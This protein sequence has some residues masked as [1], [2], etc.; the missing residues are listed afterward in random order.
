MLW[1]A[2]QLLAPPAFLAA[3]PGLASALSSFQPPASGVWWWPLALGVVAWMAWQGRGFVARSLRWVRT[4]ILLVA[5]S[6]P[7]VR[8]V[9]APAQAPRPPVAEAMKILQRANTRRYIPSHPMVAD[10]VRKL[11]VDVVLFED[12]KEWEAFHRALGAVKPFTAFPDGR[13]VLGLSAT[14]G[15]LALLHEVV[16]I[17]ASDWVGRRIDRRPFGGPDPRVQLYLNV[18]WA[19]RLDLPRA[20][21][22]QA[23]QLFAA[24]EQQFKDY[25]DPDPNEAVWNRE[26]QQQR[27]FEERWRALGF[28]LPSGGAAREYPTSIHLELPAFIYETWA[29]RRLGFPRMYGQALEA[30]VEAYFGGRLE[31]MR[32]LRGDMDRLVELLRRSPRATAIL[33]KFYREIKLPLPATTPPSPA[34]PPPAPGDAAAAASDQRFVAAGLPPR[35]AGRLGLAL[36]EA[37]HVTQ[38]AAPAQAPRAPTATQQVSRPPKPQSMNAV[39]AS[40]VVATFLRWQEAVWDQQQVELEWS[41]A[42]QR[43]WSWF[44]PPRYYDLGQVRASASLQ[45]WAARYPRL[46]AQFDKLSPLHREVTERAGRLRKGLEAQVRRAPSLMPQVIRGLHESSA[47]LISTEHVERL[48]TLDIKRTEAPMSDEA[49]RKAHGNEKY[50][51]ETTSIAILRELIR[52]LPLTREDV[53]VDIGTGYAVP[54]FYVA[55]TTPARARG[56]EL[57]THRIQE[58]MRVQRRFRF[59]RVELIEG[60]VLSQDLSDGTVFFL[61]NPLGP[62]T[63]A[64][65]GERLK[66]I[67]KGK[68]IRIVI[69]PDYAD[70]HFFSKY[71]HAQ[72]DWLRVSDRLAV[73]DESAHWQPHHVTIFESTIHPGAPSAPDM[74]SAFPQA[75]RG[76]G[77]G[78]SGPASLQMAPLVDTLRSFAVRA[79]TLFSRVLI[80][81]APVL[82]ALGLA[83]AAGP[84]GPL[85]SSSSPPPSRSRRRLPWRRAPAAALVLAL[86]LMPAWRAGSAPQSLDAA[87]HTTTA[88]RAEV[89]RKVTVARSEAWTPWRS[90]APPSR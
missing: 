27:E 73:T 53:F 3:A 65:V 41:E 5:V 23:A 50:G 7:F 71:W 21:R 79:I 20:E 34:D 9:V 66:T 14:F 13:K 90:R 31:F 47:E 28:S 37:V 19:V 39:R 17:Q 16:H 44:Y 38:A 57:A 56:I 10:L 62:E 30:D 4:A 81:L 78:S 36:L 86:S 35:L 82:F 51:Y 83:F 74:A 15:D 12:V 52:R 67:A 18:K 32:R 24:L 40:D 68:R 63:L 2:W 6:L 58:A 26:R 75:A 59:P 87:S 29:H 84:A 1:A 42:V 46:K 72:S 64:Q 25:T 77:P 70:E 60:N 88:E 49:L 76:S 8:P 61:F 22:R 55:S 54:V 69:W 11:G 43:D 48:L 45:R 85:S 80:A 89:A 33:E